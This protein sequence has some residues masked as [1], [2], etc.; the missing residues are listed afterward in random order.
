MLKS[1]DGK[2]SMNLESG[3]LRMENTTVTRVLTSK[4]E[5][6]GKDTN[7]KFNYKPNAE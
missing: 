4:D 7:F 6:C 2:T 3:E 1:N 5:S